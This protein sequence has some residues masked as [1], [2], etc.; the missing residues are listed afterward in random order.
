MKMDSLENSGFVISID[1][2]AM[3]DKSKKD[4]SAGQNDR[5]SRPEKTGLSAERLAL[6]RRRIQENFYDQD[7]IIERTAER[8]VDTRTM[9][10]HL[11]NLRKGNNS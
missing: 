8:I 4:D 3:A 2:N 6:I 7:E 1:R 11:K 9:K 10:E 5:H